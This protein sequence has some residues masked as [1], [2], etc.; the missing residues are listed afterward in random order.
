MLF[1]LKFL[2]GHMLFGLKFPISSCLIYITSLCAATD[3]EVIRLVTRTGRTTNISSG[4][5][6]VFVNGRWGTV[7]DDFFNAIDNLVACLQLGFPNPSTNG[8]V[9]N[10][11]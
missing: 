10:L 9:Q 2:L 8:N 6:E 7:C 1:G 11:R 3:G 5:L 4:R